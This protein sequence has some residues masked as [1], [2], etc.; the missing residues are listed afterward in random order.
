[1]KSEFTPITV[2]K[3]SWRY[4]A[5]M[6]LLTVLPIVC[7]VLTLKT[8]FIPQSLA[9]SIC[10]FGSAV[11]AP[12]FLVGYLLFRVTLN[13]ST[14]SVRAWKKEEKTYAFADV[15][16]SFVSPTRRRSAIRLLRKGKQIAVIHA[17]A[18]NFSRLVE[19]RH[20]GKLTEDDRRLLGRLK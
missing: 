19:L 9:L 4:P 15:S 18:K 13:G 5:G 3:A 7:G 10:F 2:R 16:W 14:V 11:I 17:D 1:M 12:I 8:D 6:L 20:H